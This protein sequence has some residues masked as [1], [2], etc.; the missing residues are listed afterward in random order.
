MIG[1]LN[2]WLLLAS[3]VFVSASFG[4]GMKVGGDVQ[5]AKAAKQL[6]RL[7]QDRKA[8]EK[9]A[10]TYAIAY[11][12]QKQTSLDTASTLRMEIRENQDKLSACRNGRAVLS[13]EFIRLRDAALQTRDAD[14]GQSSDSAAGTIDPGTLLEF[15]VENGQRWKQCRVQLN[16]LISVLKAQS[17]E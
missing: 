9:A 17:H 16:T 15:E 10:I 11:E 8:L 13:R 2:P 14:P 3:V 4:F 1:V 5:I 7:E 12:E 6:E